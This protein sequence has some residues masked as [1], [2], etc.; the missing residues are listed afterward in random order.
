MNNANT[1]SVMS[2]RSRRL[3]GDDLKNAALGEAEESVPNV[4]ESKMIVEENA[5]LARVEHVA[6]IK[7]AEKLE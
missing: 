4:E 5:V 3:S 2:I 1:S 7:E 6:K